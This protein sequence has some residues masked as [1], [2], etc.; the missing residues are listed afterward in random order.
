MTWL[1]PVELAGAAERA[2]ISNAEVV[3]MTRR[4]KLHPPS[5]PGAWKSR[6]E[7]ASK[8]KLDPSRFLEMT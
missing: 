8:L 3:E 6:L 4:G 7:P 2:V 1:D 5:F